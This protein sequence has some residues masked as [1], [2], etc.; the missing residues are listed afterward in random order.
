MEKVNKDLIKKRFAKSLESYDDEAV[1]QKGAAERMLDLLNLALL[2]RQFESVLEIGCGSG[3]LTDL[4]ESRLDYRDLLLNDI[5]PEIEEVHRHRRGSR[6]LIGDIEKSE[7]A[8]NAFDIILSNAVFQWVND[9]P[10]LLTNLHGALKPDGVLAFSTFGEHNFKEI[11]QLTA[12]KLKYFT[13]DEISAMLTDR[14][15]LL[16][17]HEEL[18]VLHFASVQKVL[19]HMRL[20]GVTATGENFSWTKGKMQK[21]MQDYYQHFT[22]GDKTVSL[23]YHPLIFIVKKK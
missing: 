9:L 23:T 20:T 3:I 4:I 11:A 19:E 16:S 2:E 8:A 13:A 14:F 15:E 6:F 12:K 10:Q 18:H 5:I 1:V 17:V 7:L 21:F 22:S